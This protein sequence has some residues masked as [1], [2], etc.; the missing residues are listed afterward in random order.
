VLVAEDEDGVRSL[1][2]EILDELGYEVLEAGRPEAAIEAMA[3]GSRRVHLLLTDVVMP[4]MNGPQL[5]ARL[6]ALQ[7][8]LRVLYMSGYTGESIARHGVLEH[9]THLLQKPFTPD[10]LA[11]KVRAVL[12]Q[13]TDR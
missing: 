5:A 10:D 4:G 13:R 9:G 3:G 11:R 2:C 8:G 1:I 7:P 6:T 12:D